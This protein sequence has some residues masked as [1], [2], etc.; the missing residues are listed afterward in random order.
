MAFKMGWMWDEG[1]RAARMD[2]T[3]RFTS[4]ATSGW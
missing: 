1:Q 2:S 4:E 3:P